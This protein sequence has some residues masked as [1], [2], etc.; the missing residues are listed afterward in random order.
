MF[1]IEWK[2]DYQRFEWTPLRSGRRWSWHSLLRKWVH[3]TMMV[4]ES[5]FDYYSYT[6]ALTSPTSF[7][8]K[9]LKQLIQQK[10][11]H[12]KRTQWRRE[13]LYHYTIS[14]C[15]KE[16]E[17]VLHVLWKSWNLSF[18]LNIVVLQHTHVLELKKHCLP[19]NV[20]IIPKHFW[21]VLRLGWMMQ[22]PVS[23]L[24]FEENEIVAIWC[25]D[26]W[27]RTISTAPFGL[28]L[29]YE[30]LKDHDIAAYLYN[31]IERLEKN[32]LLRKTVEEV[33]TF[34]IKQCVSWMHQQ[35]VFW[36]PCIL[37]CPFAKHPVFVEVL[38]LLSMQ[39]HTIWF[40]PFSWTLLSIN[41]IDTQSTLVKAR[42]QKIKK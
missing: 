35:A 29:L 2:N 10:I 25:Q 36:K 8:I 32:M 22:W 3:T 13:L 39:Y 17:P 38:E 41:E 28:T 11:T 15:M 42:V 23:V 33:F 4:Q 18:V 19:S 31:D 34:F 27:Y 40:I 7:T 5:Y 24:H 1:L 16:C 37:I 6:I 14:H 26:G 20:T 9:D 30:S 12:I 21:V